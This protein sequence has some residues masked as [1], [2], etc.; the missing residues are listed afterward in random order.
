MIIASFFRRLGAWWRARTPV[1]RAVVSVALLVLAVSRAAP[2]W[3][4]RRPVP[5][6]L[7]VVATSMML[8]E[9][10]LRPF[11]ESRVYTGWTRFVQA[12]GAV[13]AAVILS[14]VYAVAV[15]PVGLVMKLLRKDPLDRRIGPEPSFW[16]SHQPN[17]LGPDAA[18]RHQF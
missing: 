13:W 18:A 3:L 4:G 7:L 11:P 12:I 15:G 5:R 10:S 6:V 1:F 14:I 8:V 2:W 9:L 17:P 16:Q